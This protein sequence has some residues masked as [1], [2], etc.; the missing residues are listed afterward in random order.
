MKNKKIFPIICLSALILGTSTAKAEFEQKEPLIVREDAVVVCRSKQCKVASN[1]MTQ[2]FLFNKLGSLLKNNINRTISF[3]D[4]DPNTRV[5]LNDGIMF[6]VLAGAT[7]TTAYIPSA[8][9][10]DS[11]AMQNKKTQKFVLDY[12]MQLGHIYPVCQ[13]SLNQLQILSADKISVETPGFECRFTENGMTV[14]NASYEIDYIDF[15]Y[16]ILG[17]NYTIAVGQS[18]SGGGSGY[19]LMRFVNT[20]NDN[21]EIMEDCGCVCDERQNPPCRCDKDELKMENEPFSGYDIYQNNQKP[22]EQMLKDDKS[23]MNPPSVE[24]VSVLSE[25]IAFEQGIPVV[26]DIEETLPPGS[27]IAKSNWK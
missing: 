23:P 14:V 11:K 18:S 25:T 15:D 10:V 8:L 17:A 16:G 7:S 26:L 3:C 22:R 24:D 13:A 21:N 12:E 5:C 6:D 27:V 20:A 1:M 19:T 9:L 2:E 4:A